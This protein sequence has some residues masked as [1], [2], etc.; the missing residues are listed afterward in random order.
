MVS[1]LK[2][3]RE[4]RTDIARD[5]FLLLVHKAKGGGRRTGKRSGGTSKTAGTGEATVVVYKRGGKGRAG[6]WGTGWF[7]DKD[8]RRGVPRCTKGDFGEGLPKERT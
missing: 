5:D 8:V 1:Y 7:G 2:T 3:G 4:K 6:F